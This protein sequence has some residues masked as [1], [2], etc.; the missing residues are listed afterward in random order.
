MDLYNDFSDVE[1]CEL[2]HRKPIMEIIK[3]K[4]QMN[5]L[6]VI[7]GIR[8]NQVFFLYLIARSFRIVFI[9]FLANGF[10]IQEIDYEI[11]LAYCSSTFEILT[12][13]PY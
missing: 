12:I 7:V 10:Y 5:R 2:L 6:S 11:P 8:I 1:L 3:T 13:Q 4:K 9:A